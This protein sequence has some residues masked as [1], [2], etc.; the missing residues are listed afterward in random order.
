[1]LKLMGKKMFSIL[2]RN[3]LLSKPVHMRRFFNAFPAS[4]QCTQLGC[5]SGPRGLNEQNILA[6]NCNYL[7]TQP[8][9]YTF[10]VLKRMETVL[11]STYNI[12]FGWKILKLIFNYVLLFGA[13]SST[14]CLIWSG[15]KL[16]DTDGIPER[17]F[18]KIL[19]KLIHHY[20]HHRYH[21]HHVLISMEVQGHHPYQLVDPHHVAGYLHT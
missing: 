1:M 14:K 20:I 18:G 3:F 15:S 17:F 16:L 4:H 9:K 7:L 5:R 12:C 8:S 19:E 13:W 10:R 6:L 21:H 11:L 2:R